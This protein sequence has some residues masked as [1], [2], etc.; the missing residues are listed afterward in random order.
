ML[1]PAVLEEVLTNLSATD[2]L[3]VDEAVVQT[4][5][6]LERE[7]RYR[8][9]D[10][11]LHGSARR[12]RGFPHL[13]PEDC[14]QRTRDEY[15]QMLWPEILDGRLTSEQEDAIVSTL[16]DTL[17]GAARRSGVVFAL[18]RSRRQSLIPRLTAELRQA[19]GKDAWL[20][21]QTITRPRCGSSRSPAPRTAPDAAAE[22]PQILPAGPGPRYP[23]GR[24]DGPAG[25]PAPN[26]GRQCQSRG[27]RR[28]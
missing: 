5:A 19:I 13:A 18:G 14:H 25:R 27:R 16:L 6:L 23:V 28:R 8:S 22:P 7:R 20:V 15:V 1:D 11:L 21:H 9:C 3:T 17:A 12:P 24:L 2:R 10:E 26:T 4:A